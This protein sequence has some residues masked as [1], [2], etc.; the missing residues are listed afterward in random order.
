[1]FIAL[2]SGLTISLE[3]ESTD[4]TPQEY[5]EP[6]AQDQVIA[7]QFSFSTRRNQQDQR[8]PRPKS[9]LIRNKRN[10]WYTVRFEDGLPRQVS[11]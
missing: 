5:D 3:E 2:M 7:N 1:M 9:D 4:K 11:V 10:T 6:Q 8:N